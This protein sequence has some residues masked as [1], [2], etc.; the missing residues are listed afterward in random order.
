MAVGEKKGLLGTSQRW[1]IELK[2]FQENYMPSTW[3]KVT[4]LLYEI[5][6]GKG[7]K[8]WR[9]RCSNTLTQHAEVN[10]LE[11]AFGKLQFNHPV[12]CHITWFL[13]WSPCGRCCRRIL[14]FLQAHPHVTLVIKAAQLFKH[15]DERN[16]QGL[17]DLVQNGVH[18]QVMDLPDY[19]YCWRTFV[20]HPHE[21]E[22]DFWPW[23]FPLWITFYNQELQHILLVS[24]YFGKNVG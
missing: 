20:T 18:V 15:M 16:R 19:R 12:P 7:S 2:S 11:N 24:R 17:R 23:F 6:W 10:C 9:N 21:G 14:Q 8:V 5:R 13:S 4:H 22:S 1:K 3:P